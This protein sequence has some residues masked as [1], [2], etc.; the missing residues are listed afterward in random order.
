MITI[1]GI[2]L[3]CVFAFVS[4]L[5]L[6]VYY[7]HLPYLREDKTPIFLRVLLR[8]AF[9]ALL[10]VCVFVSFGYLLVLLTWVFIGLL[11]KAAEYISYVVG[12]VFV[13]TSVV[14]QFLAVHA[15]HKRVISAVL[16]QVDT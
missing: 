7:A 8:R 13:A 11:F 10:F 2:S 4:V 5:E 14:R 1:L 3:S 12:V 9:Y 15:I 6:Y 16:D